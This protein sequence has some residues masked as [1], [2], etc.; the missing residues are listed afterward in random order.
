M[1]GAKWKLVDMIEDTIK[2]DIPRLQ[3]E[4]SRKVDS[5]NS[6]NS[7]FSAEEF[8]ELLRKHTRRVTNN[9]ISAGQELTLS[10]GDQLTELIN[11]PSNKC[12]HFVDARKDKFTGSLYAI[13]HYVMFGKPAKRKDIIGMEKRHQTLVDRALGMF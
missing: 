12:G 10:W 2:H 6:G 5:I 11:N 1:F 9:V 13:C 8:E 4:V 3:N 7:E